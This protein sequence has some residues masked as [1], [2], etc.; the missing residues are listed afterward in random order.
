MEAEER[1]RILASNYEQE[2]KRS[3]ALS[4]E[5]SHKTT[6]LQRLKKRI[7][8][9]EADVSEVVMNRSTDPGLELEIKALQEEKQ[10]LLEMIPDE[11]FS[12]YV[13]DSGG[14][15]RYMKP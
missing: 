12:S 11:E 6:E 5:V 1:C 8:K 4:E 10:R 15:V 14:D 7:S 9:M 2:R 3:Q 13:A